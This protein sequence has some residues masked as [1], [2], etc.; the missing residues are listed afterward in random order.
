MQGLLRLAFQ[1]NYVY[2]IELKNKEYGNRSFLEALQT[3][4]LFR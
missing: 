3:L 2:L 1:I 4:T